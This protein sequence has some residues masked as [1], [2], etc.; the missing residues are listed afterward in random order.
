MT[1]KQSTFYSKSDFNTPTAVNAHHNYATFNQSNK[2]QSTL[3]KLLSREPRGTIHFKKDK[4]L[5]LRL[6]CD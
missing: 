3:H 6:I 2:K 1:D 5:K 4:N